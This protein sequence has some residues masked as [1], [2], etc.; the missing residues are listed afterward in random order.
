MAAKVAIDLETLG[1]QAGNIIISIGAVRFTDEGLQAR[2]IDQSADD[3]A[4]HKAQWEF[5]REISVKSCGPL[6]LSFDHDTMAWWMD[7]PEASV[8]TLRAALT[9]KGAHD[10]RQVLGD[11]KAWL[12]SGEGCDELWSWH[13]VFDLGI[14]KTAYNRAGVTDPWDYRI[15][16]DAATLAPYVGVQQPPSEGTQHNALDDA[17]WCARYVIGMKQ[18]LARAAEGVRMVQGME[19]QR[20]MLKREQERTK[21]VMT[22]R[23][24]YGHPLTHWKVWLESKHDSQTQTGGDVADPRAEEDQG[25]RYGE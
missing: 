2:V 20:E 7:Q 12:E 21:D 10:I 22:P 5:Y 8:K 15:E 9:G 4:R 23:D 1:K 17:R 16:R 18:W 13:S 24:I 25:G 3:L 6:G 11:F 19:L 14:L